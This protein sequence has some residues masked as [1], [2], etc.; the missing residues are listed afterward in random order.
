MKTE[1]MNKV[2]KELTGIDCNESIEER[3]CPFCHTAIDITE[4]RDKLSKREWEISGLC[5]KC[6][7]DMF[8]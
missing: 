7:D 2:I 8:G 4:F 5:Q 6:Q 3:V 1:E